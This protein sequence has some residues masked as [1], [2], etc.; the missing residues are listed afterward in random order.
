MLWVG[1]DH[2]SVSAGRCRDADSKIRPAWAADASDKADV[3]SDVSE[4]ECKLS[5]YI[6]GIVDMKKTGK[7]LSRFRGDEGGSIGTEYGVLMVIIALGMAVAAGL[8]GAAITNAFES[9][10]ACLNTIASFNRHP[11][12]DKWNR[13]PVW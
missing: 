7:F 4:F 10:A 3:S 8:L 6:Q 2:R 11:P 1:F 12:S 13:A 5:Y 9:G